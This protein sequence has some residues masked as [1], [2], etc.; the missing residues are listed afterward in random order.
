M[1][2]DERTFSLRDTISLNAHGN[3]NV[4]TVELILLI[5]LQYGAL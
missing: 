5:F 4:Q 1:M 2:S 3:K